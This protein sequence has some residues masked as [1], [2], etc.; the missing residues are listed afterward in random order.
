M[1]LEEKTLMISSMEVESRTEAC[2]YHDDRNKFMSV[3]IGKRIIFMYR[4]TMTSS[5]KHDFHDVS[6]PACILKNKSNLTQTTRRIQLISWMAWSKCEI[7]EL[8]SWF[9]KRSRYKEV[10]IFVFS[11]IKK[12]TRSEHD[13]IWLVMYNNKKERR[14]LCRKKSD[15]KIW[16]YQ[17]KRS[18]KVSKSWMT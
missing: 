8:Y 18:S 4:N 16:L 1:H 9:L 6:Q 2:V 5:Y 7:Y 3:Q 14:R 17:S 10:L 11:F 13:I 15:R 12:L